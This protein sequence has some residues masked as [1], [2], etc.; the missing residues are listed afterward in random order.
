MAMGLSSVAFLLCLKASINNYK[1]IIP[2]I[3]K[4]LFFFYN[5]LKIKFEKL[6]NLPF[7]VWE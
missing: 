3:K 6:I 5:F 1:K 7:L 4:I 2:I